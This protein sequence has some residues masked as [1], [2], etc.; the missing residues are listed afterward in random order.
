MAGR[1]ICWGATGAALLVSAMLWGSPPAQGAPSRTVWRVQP[2]PP[3]GLAA[4]KNLWMDEAGGRAALTRSMGSGVFS[5]SQHW[6]FRR[7]GGTIPQPWYQ[8]YN[9]ASGACLYKVLNAPVPYAFVGG[10]TTPGPG[11]VR[12]DWWQFTLLSNQAVNPGLLQSSTD[13]RLYRIHAFYHGDCLSLPYSEYQ[14]GARLGLEKCSA[15]STQH[16]WLYRSS[17]P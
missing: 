2:A 17:M 4:R 15:S 8:V 11:S 16:W 6:A 5:R 3:G 13:P 1:I 10:C 14:A 9:V 12:T 7:V